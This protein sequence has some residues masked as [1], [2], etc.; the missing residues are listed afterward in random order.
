M[1]N[2]VP[3]RGGFFRITYSDD[4]WR[5][6]RMILGKKVLFLREIKVR[7]EISC[8]KNLIQPG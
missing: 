1:K 3:Q 4:L 5:D 6:A 2:E 7:M 8:M